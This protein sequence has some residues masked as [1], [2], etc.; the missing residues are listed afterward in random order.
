MNRPKQWFVMVFVMLLV[1][2]L[3]KCNNYR[4][5]KSAVELKHA[6]RSYFKYMNGK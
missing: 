4:L 3:D 6:S 2:M 1:R 5:F